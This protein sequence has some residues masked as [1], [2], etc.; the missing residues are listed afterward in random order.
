M[1]DKNQFISK[2]KEYGR[3]KKSKKSAVEVSVALM[4]DKENA[5]YS[6][7]E[8]IKKSIDEGI[9]VSEV[10]KIYKECG[11][12]YS[13][14][15]FDRSLKKL[16]LS[17]NKKDFDLEKDSVKNELVADKEPLNNGVDVGD[18]FERVINM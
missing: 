13:R 12:K 16:G 2:I 15:T 3:E 11:Y 9:S 5:K 4:L 14:A 1:I 8:I 10:Y 18:E 7:Y 6:S 17:V